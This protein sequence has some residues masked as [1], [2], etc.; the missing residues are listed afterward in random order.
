[1]RTCGAMPVKHA[2]LSW[3]Y[4]HSTRLITPSTLNTTFKTIKKSQQILTDI[5]FVCFSSACLKFDNF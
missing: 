4:K 5:E 3:T 1:M 2:W